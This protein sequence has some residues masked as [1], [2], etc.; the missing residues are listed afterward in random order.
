MSYA[1]TKQPGTTGTSRPARLPG[2][3]VTGLLLSRLVFFAVFQVVAALLLAAAGTTNAWTASAAWWPLTAAAANL[4]SL[5]VLRA[6]LRREGAGL[7][8]FYRPHAGSWEGDLWRLLLV[9]LAGGALAAGTNMML[10]SWL[11]GDPQGGYMLLVQPLPLWAAITAVVLFPVTTALAELPTYYGYLQPRLAQLSRHGWLVVLVPAL[12]H[13][14][15]HITL[16][17]LFDATYLLWR[18]LMFLPFALLLSWA[19]RRRP[20]LLPYLVVIHFLLDLQAALAVLAVAQ[21]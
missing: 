18:G 13:A 17:V 1:L 21:G 6:L 10:A 14:L 3:L 20:S 5:G 11:Y 19:L 9:T 7:A 12:F 16:P 8:G 2:T 15:Q 4:V